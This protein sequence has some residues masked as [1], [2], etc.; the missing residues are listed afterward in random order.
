MRDRVSHAFKIVT[1]VVMAK[2]SPR[3]RVETPPT[4]SA[5]GAPI[6]NVWVLL[7]SDLRLRLRRNGDTSLAAELSVRR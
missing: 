6:P 7:T 4:I 5:A 3:T 1:G 2:M